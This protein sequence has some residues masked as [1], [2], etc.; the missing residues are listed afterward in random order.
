[1]PATVGYRLRS[2]GRG[3]DTVLTKGGSAITETQ[4][5]AHGARVPPQSVALPSAPRAAA[6][7]RR[8]LRDVLVE[9]PS[10]ALETALLLS[11]ELVS[12]AV[13]HGAPPIRLLVDLRPGPGLVRVSVEDGD[14][15]LPAR[16]EAPPDPL[17]LPPEHGRGLL[18][19]DS[20][21]RRWGIEQEPPGKQVWFELDL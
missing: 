4:G 6:E 5:T 8:F 18:L 12:N 20:L 16:R 17:G 7:A 13:N 3:A 1:M 11:S 15:R 10:E 21:A 9:A 19:L 14:P 2:P